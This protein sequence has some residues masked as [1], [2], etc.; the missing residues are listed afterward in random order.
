MRAVETR[1][2]IEVLELMADSERSVRKEMLQAAAARLRDQ[3]KRI[4]ELREQLRN[5]DAQ[6]CLYIDGHY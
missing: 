6:I 3:E 2:L 4:G 1:T 5:A